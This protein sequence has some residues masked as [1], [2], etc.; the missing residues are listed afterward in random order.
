M[1]GLRVD[2]WVASGTLV[3]HNYDSLLAKVM[4]HADSRDAAISTMETALQGTR[5]KGIPTNQQLLEATL[6][7]AE[8]RG[9]RYDTHVLLR[10]PL[11][12]S[13]LE[14]RPPRV[15][16]GASITFFKVKRNRVAMVAYSLPV[17]PCSCVV[18]G[19][20]ASPSPACNRA[21]LS[22]SRRAA[23]HA[24]HHGGSGRPGA[25]ATAARGHQAAR[26]RC[27]MSSRCGRAR[28]SW[29]PVS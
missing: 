16:L 11:D 1:P 26:C 19:S 7:F 10:L 2:T 3:S 9:G 12:K 15:S 17:L 27:A 21:P 24:S 18:H 22:Q 25:A 29:R 23:A 5:V 28:R 6:A 20:A 14:V 4:T 13:F 8:F